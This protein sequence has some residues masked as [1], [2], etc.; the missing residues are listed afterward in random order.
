MA[1]LMNLILYSC[2]LY[3]IELQILQTDIRT[4][5]LS[6][7]VGGPLVSINKPQDDE[8]EI[9]PIFYMGLIKNQSNQDG[10]YQFIYK[11]PSNSEE[12]TSATRN[13]QLTSPIKLP[14]SRLVRNYLKTP[15]PKKRPSDSHCFSCKSNMSSV[16]HSVA[17]TVDD[18][19]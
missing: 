16:G 4:P 9:R 6:S 3:K 15:S 7:G 10:H 18:L 5:I 8:N 19:D 11:H 1:I 2:K 17:H 13:S 12:S 14:R